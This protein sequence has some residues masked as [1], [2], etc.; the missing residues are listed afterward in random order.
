MELVSL[1]QC[2][3]RGR[4]RHA[5]G[6]RCSV[7]L[8]YDGALVRPRADRARI[9]TVNACALCWT[10]AA[11]A[12]RFAPAVRFP[13][14]VVVRLAFVAG[15]QSHRLGSRIARLAARSLGT[16]ERAR[17]STVPRGKFE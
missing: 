4:D 3:G 8:T 12:S 7:G 2:L 17:G 13:A 6:D 14:A 15:T 16:T 9:I 1:S 5:R 10:T 11:S